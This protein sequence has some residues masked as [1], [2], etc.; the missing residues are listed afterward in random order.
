MWYFVQA[1]RRVTAARRQAKLLAE[2]GYYS[3]ILPLAGLNGYA[4][5]AG[6]AAGAGLVVGLAFVVVGVST[7]RWGG[8]PRRGVAN[9]SAVLGRPT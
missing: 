6:W 7:R 3:V 4:S 2:P 1:R 5:P 8:S 9:F